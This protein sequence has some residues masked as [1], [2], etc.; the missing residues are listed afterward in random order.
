MSSV[1]VIPARGGS[2]GI[3]RKSIRPVAGRPMIAWAIDACRQFG[4]F[5]RV[6]VSTDDAEIALLSERLGADVLMRP[7][8]LATDAATLDPVVAHAVSSAE[9]RFGERYELVFTIQP[10]SPLVEPGDFGRACAMF[11]ADPLLDTVLSVVDDRHLFWTL[12][13]GR[14]V[15]AYTKRVNR[16][17]L[18]PYFRETGAVIACRRSQLDRGSRIGERVALLE[19]PPMR[20]FDIDSVADLAVCEA[21]LLRKRI[22]FAV[23]GNPEVGLGHAFRATMLAHELVRHDLRFVCDSRS[24]LA[25]DH[26]SRQNWNVEVAP[27]GG[28][29]DA[30]LAHR[31]HLVINDLLDTGIGYVQALKAVGC[32]VVNFEDL[33]DGALH[34]DLVINALYPYAGDPP[35]VLTGA[36]WFCLRDEFLYTKRSAERPRVERVLIT[37][38]GVDEGDLTARVLR[39][40]GPVAAARGI[41]LDVVV[42]PGYAHQESLGLAV[43]DLARRWPELRVEVTGATARISDHMRDAD[44][45]V[46]SG[47]RTVFE[48]VSL[49]VPSVVICQNLREATHTFAVAAHDVLNLGWRGAVDDAGIVGPIERLIDDASARSRMREAAIR[50]D[51]TAGKRRVIGRL[52]GLLEDPEIE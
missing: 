21:M 43:S 9:T 41:V 45:A 42:G 35:H 33:G 40:L 16:Q 24:G 47:G 48:L 26:I 17:Q 32:R 50:V 36:R 4:R 37:F 3:P 22:V 25:A 20:A 38:G 10:T 52:L 49:A 46:T 34:A 5:S 23:I 8:E 6:V 27:Q 18:A 7:G 28:L 30:V 44:L 29:L 1:A 31:P 13:D 19:M 51:L 11:A 39:L 2:K 15:P 12:R 14:P